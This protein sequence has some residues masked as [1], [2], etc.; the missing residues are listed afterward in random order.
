ML[1]PHCPPPHYTEAEEAL[2]GALL[3]DSSTFDDVSEL[4]DSED[5]YHLANSVIFQ[6]VKELSLENTK[7]DPLL[8]YNLLRSKGQLVQ[9]GGGERIEI[10]INYTPSAAN[11]K[12]YARLVRQAA[13]ERKLLSAS[14]GIAN[15]VYDRQL[16]AGDKLERAEELLYSIRDQ[17]SKGQL[18]QVQGP[19]RKLFEKLN[20]LAQ[21]QGAISGVPTG[22][23]ELDR[24]TSGLQP[25]N[26]CI[27]GARP[28]MGK[29]AFAL[30]LA[31]NVALAPKPRGQVAIFSLEMSTEDLL[32]RMLCS[33]SK[34]NSQK[35]KS[36][37]LDCAD[38]ERLANQLE[39]IEKAPLF[40]ND[41]GGVS[42]LEIRADL[43]RLS[44][45]GE[46]ALVIIDYL[47]LVRGQKSENR[48]QEVS[49]ISRQLKE[50]AKEFGC[51]ILALSQLS[52]SLESRQNKRPC[53]SDL[54]ES[55]SI[56]QDA[57][58]VC[59]LYRDEYYYK[60]SKERQIAE[61]IVAKQRNGPVGSC[62]L[63]FDKEHGAFSNLANAG[64]YKR[65]RN[66]VEPLCFLFV[67][68]FLLPYHITLIL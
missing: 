4:V 59:F 5:F 67:A 28:S 58:L 30:A 39:Q 66:S 31:L 34:A 51:P 46:I 36:G 50:L 42:I 55:G 57:D 35:A 18:V 41:Q 63:H 29:T 1:P 60:E 24:L 22:F 6:A 17:K 37:R 38:L 20:S 49:A 40:I 65:G 14:T 47:Q 23:A 7:P 15:L 19:A 2:I 43:R 16:E 45:Q 10:L 13:L 48:T 64:S 11:A 26:L 32:L 21:G 44:R 56:E 3:V 62:R 33:L 25:S 68:L 52:R 12:H 61:V 54:R 9:A 8:V 27:L 53:L